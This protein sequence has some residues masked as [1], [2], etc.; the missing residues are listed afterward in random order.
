MADVIG[1]KICLACKKEKLFSEFGRQA[2]GAGGLRPS[3]KDCRRAECA[4]WRQKNPD[5]RRQYYRKNIDADK[6]YQQAR[7]PRR[8]GHGQADRRP[9][10]EAA[11][12]KINAKSRLYY[13]ANRDRL[14][15]E[16]L[17]RA[18]KNPAV[19]AEA[20]RKRHAVKL[21]ALMPWTDRQAI[22]TYYQLAA[23]MTRE[24]GEKWH[25]DHI[26]PLQ[27]ELVCGLHVQC[28]LD[29]IQASANIAK[30]NRHWPDMP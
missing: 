8:T 21:R 5:Y 29:V 11:R 10:D 24:T 4:E 6:R 15:A 26:V 20:A 22:L 2:D 18:K 13:A 23:A 12:E 9:K 28:N 27:S 14:R 25:V 16:A 30:G 19:F 3:C 1:T 17:E 7:Y